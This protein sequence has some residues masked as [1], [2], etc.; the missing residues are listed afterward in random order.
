MGSFVVDGQVGQIGAKLAMNMVDPATMQLDKRLASDET[1]SS[2]GDFCKSLGATE[3]NYWQHVYDRIGIE[4]TS[5]S[6]RGN[7]P[8]AINV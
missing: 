3:P 4:Y 7:R 8:V 5:D 2:F 6:P 1:G